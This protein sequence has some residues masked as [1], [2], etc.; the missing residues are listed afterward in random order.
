MVVKDARGTTIEQMV[1]YFPEADLILLEGGKSFPYPKIEV[2]R[3]GAL[4][5]CDPALLL[6]ICADGDFHVKDVPSFPL[7]DYE[8]IATLIMESVK[9]R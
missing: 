2:V 3:N 6:A 9:V 7:S 1:E 5:V 4:S 8:G